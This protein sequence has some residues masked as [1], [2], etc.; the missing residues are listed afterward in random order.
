[1]RT[2]LSAM[3]RMRNP[4]VWASQKKFE[5]ET[6]FMEGIQKILLGQGEVEATLKEV[7]AKIAQLQAE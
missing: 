1:V 7:D 2:F 5:I 6:A 4:N 3:S